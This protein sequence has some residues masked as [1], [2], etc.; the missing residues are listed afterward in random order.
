MTTR[1]PAAIYPT[2]D[3]AMADGWTPLGRDATPVTDKRL[4]QAGALMVRSDGLLSDLVMITA[5][6]RPG[7]G[8]GVF[9]SLYPPAQLA[10]YAADVLGGV[11]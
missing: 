9:V 5:E 3:A 2:R 6:R 8:T 10:R 1:G 7:G 11:A 4:A